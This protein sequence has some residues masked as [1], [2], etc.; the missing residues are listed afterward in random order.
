MSQKVG[1][2]VEGSVFIGFSASAHK[3]RSLVRNSYLRKA[4][5]LLV[6]IIAPCSKFACGISHVGQAD[7][8]Q[9]YRDSLRGAA[10]LVGSSRLFARNSAKF[11]FEVARRGGA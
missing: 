2:G 7:C 6:L 10:R 4:A 5:L 1:P 8:P 3:G 11:L 9:P